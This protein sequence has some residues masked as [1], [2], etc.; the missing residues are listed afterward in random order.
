MASTQHVVFSQEINIK[1]QFSINKQTMFNKS[2]HSYLPTY[3]YTNYFFDERRTMECERP[4]ISL[5]S[6]DDDISLS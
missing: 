4:T 5:V 2:I 1:Q 6:T 3:Q